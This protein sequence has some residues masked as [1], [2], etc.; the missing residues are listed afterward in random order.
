MQAVVVTGASSGIGRATALRMARDGAAVLAVGRQL[1][2][3]E[4][5]AQAIRA[6][7][8]R[9][10]PLVMDVVAAHAPAAIVEAVQRSF[11]GLTALVNAAGIIGTGSIENTTDEAWDQMLDVNLRA[12]FRLMRAAVPLLTTSRGAIVNVSSVTGTR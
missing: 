4:E 10:E 3:L 7:N 1:P 6:E 5:L 2:A 11:G 12:A 9:C 8:G